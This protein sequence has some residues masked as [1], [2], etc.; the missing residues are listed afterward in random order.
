MKSRL[1]L[2]LVY[3]KA[4]VTKEL[5]FKATAMDIRDPGTLAFFLTLPVR[6]GL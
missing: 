4:A 2:L 6:P 3:P 5:T 1:H